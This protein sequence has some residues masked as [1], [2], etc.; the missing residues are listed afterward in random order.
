MT[1]TTLGFVAIAAL[2]ACTHHRKMGDMAELAGHDVQVEL[3]T[4]ANE[5]EG[6]VLRGLD[7]TG[8][9]VHTPRGVF[10][11]VEIKTVTIVRRGT[12]ALEGLGIGAGVGALAGILLGLADGDD[13]CNTGRGSDFCSNRTAAD[14]AFVLGIV[15]G[16]LGGLIGLAIGGVAGSDFVYEP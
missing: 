1:Q 10:R 2:G 12:G 3:T 15:V 8:Y 14:N 5:E 16:G 11:P 13:E 6:R 7:G 4:S 9:A